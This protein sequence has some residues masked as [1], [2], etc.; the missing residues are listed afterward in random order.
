VVSS[1]I[2]AT[3][4]GKPVT[5][6]P[7]DL[8]VPP[9]ALEVLLDSFTGPLDLLLYLIRKQNIDIMD[10]PIAGIT[11]QY[12]HYIALMEHHRMELAADYL[13]M[14]AILVEIKARFL[15]PVRAA[16]LEEE[17]EDPRMELVRRLKIYEQFKEVAEAFNGID[18]YD[19][20]VFTV[21]VAPLLAKHIKP[22]PEVPLSSLVTA[23]NAVL[24]RKNHLLSH[25]VTKEPLSVNARMEDIL[26]QVNSAGQTDLSALLLAEEGRLGLV[27][28]FIAVLELSRQKAI[29]ITQV[30]AFSPLYIQ[31]VSNG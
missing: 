21:E 10:I 2:V 25:H 17:P 7:N 15:L 14:A 27:V 29:T 18:R 12:T 30:R 8:F 13:V 9:D 20:N 16:D 6:L 28:T 31:A 26:M 4:A 24:S 19:R 3:V 23:M 22:V 11:E 5:E 1:T